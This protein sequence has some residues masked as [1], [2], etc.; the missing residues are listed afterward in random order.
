MQVIYRLINI[1]TIAVILLA[2]NLSFGQDSNNEFSV[3]GHIVD[4]LTHQ[5]L[6][7]VNVALY[8]D[9]GN[10]IIS[11]LS[12]SGGHFSL[13]V[14]KEG[15]YTIH[16]AYVGYGKYISNTVRVVGTYQVDLGE[17]NLQ[18]DA[19]NLKEIVV[20]SKK[21]LIQNKGDKIVYN[22]DA[23]ISN[24][25][26]SAVDVLKKAP[27]LTVDADGS[28]KIRGNSNLKVLLN[29]LP[30][31]ILARN[32]TEALK[33]IPAN[34]IQSVEVI[35]TPSAK[36]EAE[37]AAGVINIITKKIRTTSGNINLSAGNLEQTANGGLSIV[38][39]KFTYN[40]S[41]FAESRRRKTISD[42]ER[43]SIFND[44]VIG[45]LNQHTNSL[46]KE[47]GTYG[48]F[49]TE[50]RPDSTQKIGASVS[51]WGGQWPVQSNVFNNYTGGLQTNT[52]NQISD[53]HGNFDYLQLALNY[54][55]NFKRTGQELQLLA[56]ASGERDKMGYT[57]S[58]YDLSGTSYFREES[59]NLSGGTNVNVQIDYT[60][61]INKSGKNLLETG[62][63]FSNDDS[64]SRYAVY[65]NQNN[66]QSDDLIKDLSRSDTMMY[67]QNVFAAYASLKFETKNGWIIRPGIRYET[68]NLGAHFKGPSPAFN[69]SFANL[70]PNFM[71][72]KKLNEQHNIRF[73]Y[74]ERI[75]RPWI[76]D[77]NPY[78]NASDSRNLTYG[79][80]QLRPE[81]TR[82]LEFTEGYSGK[83]GISVS[84]S[85]YFSFNSNAIESITTIDSLVVSRTT[86]RNIGFNKRIGFNLNTYFPI[87]ENWTVNG[88]AEYY[89][90]WLG[91]GALGISNNGNFYSLNLNS[92]YKLPNDY[93]M[94]VSGNYNNRTTNLQGYISTFY[95]YQF[96]GRKEFFKKKASLTLNINNPFQQ[97]LKQKIFSTAT[98]FINSNY[99]N[100]YNRS[101]TVSLIYRFGKIRS[102]DNYSGNDNSS[103]SPIIR[104]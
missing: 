59:P 36:Y 86:S 16:A 72:S 104:R 11:A 78:I 46:Q 13:P 47:N 8:D 41:L 84:T 97:S 103:S 77:L 56:Q 71:L 20:T 81:V 94:Q 61:P 30:S 80:P 3:K 60:Q 89:H 23:D 9:K 5:S 57:T 48:E 37:G 66:P 100:Y 54:Q 101:F 69:A 92:S 76:W 68:T 98:T 21:A 45:N 53:A 93:T 83:G 7:S 55:K 102:Q 10:N 15:I 44:K 90:I 24:A 70:L 18:R 91:S 49:S 58:Q 26:G 88:G 25:S 32:L 40:L 29:G 74:T 95:S 96:S 27:M 79:N 65:N 1:L 17:L 67:F 4:S 6:S 42:L 85:A 34:T 75:R 51:Y 38:K 19:S 50:F 87:T 62:A 14:L 12:D 99:S 43:Q 82:L 35:T 63:R 39:K 2:G 52:Y 64:K 73:N 31:G 28:V 22:A 33:M